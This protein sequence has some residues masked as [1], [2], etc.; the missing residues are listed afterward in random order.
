MRRV[1][2]ALTVVG[3]YL[4]IR[5][6]Q[7]H[8]STGVTP[9]SINDVW[10]CGIVNRGPYSVIL[11]VPVALIGI[12][13]YTFLFVIEGLKKWRL[14]AVA[15][16]CALAFSLYLT[17]IEASILQV[18][19]EYCVGSLITISLITLL[20]IIQLIVHRRP[21]VAEGKAATTAAK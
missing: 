1:I 19:C 17:H 3:V 20:S 2:M 7:I 6:L 10:D 4:A 14:M 18:W 16:V 9:C 5:A 21:G 15:C 8:Y 12:V 11:G 13:G